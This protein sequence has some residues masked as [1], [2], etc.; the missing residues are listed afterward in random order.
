MK[1]KF[2]IRGNKVVIFLNR[3]DKST[4]ET[5]IDLENLPRMQ[6][7]TGTLV[8]LWDPGIRSFYAGIHMKKGDK[9]TL[10]YLHRLLM[11]TPDGLE[12]D[13]DNHDTLLNTRKNLKNVTKSRNMQNTGVRKTNT[14]GF[15][16]VTWNKARSKWQARIRVNGKSMYLGLY[17]D[18]SLAAQTVHETQIKLMSEVY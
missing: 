13:H 9:R 4:L 11:N 8:A 10:I 12:V 14:S 17:I 5:V 16:G 7:I 6:E 2:E 1:N 18:L 3:K 15:R